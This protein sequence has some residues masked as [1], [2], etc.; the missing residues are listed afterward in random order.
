M[1]KAVANN[2]LHKALLQLPQWA[3]GMHGI[4]SITNAFQIFVVTF[5]EFIYSNF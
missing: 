3:E 2:L 1:K 4:D 5:L